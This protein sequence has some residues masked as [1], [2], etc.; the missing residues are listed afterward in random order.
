MQAQNSTDFFIT[1]ALGKATGMWKFLI[2]RSY[3]PCIKLHKDKKEREGRK[4][5]N[6]T[7]L[8]VA[9]IIQEESLYCSEHDVL[10]ET[11]AISI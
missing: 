5:I 11:T 6:N 7:L 9:A 8:A 2:F 3:E 10:A 4:K 1:L